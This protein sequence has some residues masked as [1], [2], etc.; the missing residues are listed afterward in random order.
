MLL[1]QE[2]PTL[3]RRR[4]KTEVSWVEAFGTE[5]EA[6]TTELK[7][8]IVALIEEDGGQYRIKF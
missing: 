2:Q 1:S 5:Y 7:A 8:S 3:I 6:L 4:D